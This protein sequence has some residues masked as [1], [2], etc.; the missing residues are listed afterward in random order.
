M[1][2]TSVSVILTAGIGQVTA[3]IRDFNATIEKQD[4]NQ[5]TAQFG[6]GRVSSIGKI[7]VRTPAGPA[8]FHVMN[9]D[10]PFLLCL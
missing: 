1:L 4:Y 5:V 7:E 10:L 9:A 8:I 3:Y 2:D 6:V